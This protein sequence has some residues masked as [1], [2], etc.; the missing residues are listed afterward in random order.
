MW[1]WGLQIMGQQCTDSS[2]QELSGVCSELPEKCQENTLLVWGP[3]T[4]AVGAEHL[5][6]LKYTVC[7]VANSQ[8][9][10]GNVGLLQ[11]GLENCCWIRKDAGFRCQPGLL[12]P[13]LSLTFQCMVLGS[14]IVS[15]LDKSL[16]S[17]SS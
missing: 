9:S 14:C 3:V 17:F 1:V 8:L 13:K 6:S 5:Q 7:A 11:H 4:S 16:L 10:C 15:S 12:Q 2:L